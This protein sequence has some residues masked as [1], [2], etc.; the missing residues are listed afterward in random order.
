MSE[1]KA[2]DAKIRQRNKRLRESP[3]AKAHR[4]EKARAYKKSEA[5]KKALQKYNRKQRAR[6]NENAEKVEA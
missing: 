6:S 2:M 3:E 1:K 5:G 4:L